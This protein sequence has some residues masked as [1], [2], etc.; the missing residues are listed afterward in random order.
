MACQYLMRACLASGDAVGAL[1]AY[2]QL[3]EHLEQEYDIEP[4]PA[5]QELAVAIKR[6]N[7][8]RRQDL[9]QC[10]QAGY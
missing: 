3:W 10:A 8:R 6:G 5:T 1:A 7:Y 4:S 9:S 2:K